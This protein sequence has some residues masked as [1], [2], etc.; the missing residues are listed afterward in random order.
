MKA[1]HEEMKDRFKK[2]NPLMDVS[3]EK[4]ECQD[5]NRP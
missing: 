1:G 5:R 4:M 3:L 2:M